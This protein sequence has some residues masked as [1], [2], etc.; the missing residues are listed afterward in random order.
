MREVTLGPDDLL[1]LSADVLAQG[2]LFR[3][4]ACGG[5]MRPAIQDGD[6]L[7]LAPVS[8]DALAVGDVVLYR[9]DS[10]RPVVHR[11]IARQQDPPLLT[12]RGDAQTGPG[13]RVP[14]DRVI[15]R[16]IDV[17]RGASSR[18]S[19][20]CA[21]LRIGAIRVLLWLQGQK[22]YRALI[23]RLLG[24]RIQYRPATQA[25]AAA[26]SRLYGGANS[27]NEMALMIDHMT[28]PGYILV[29]VLVNRVIGRR[30]AGAATVRTFPPT[31]DSFF[32]QGWWIF[33]L[34]VRARYR[35]L[36]IGQDLIRACLDKAR[37]A[38][39]EQVCLFVYEDNIPAIRLYEKLGFCRST[40]PGLSEALA[41]EMQAGGRPRLVLTR[42]LDPTEAT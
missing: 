9:D 17:Q 6:L 19:G 30:L 34:Q 5:S 36:G 11:L 27:P 18:T 8:S 40:I 25:D 26:L 24:G 42:H 32:H 7:T 29:A 37:E 31:A 15:G 21:A 41:Q 38:G 1:A 22:G 13:E 4:Q 23:R 33:G 20:P 28:G 3:F 10:D 16:V 2:G 35:R 14:P 12:I 39:E